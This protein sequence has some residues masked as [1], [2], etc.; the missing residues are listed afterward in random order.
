MCVVSTSPPCHG[1]PTSRDKPTPAPGIDTLTANDASSRARKLRHVCS[2]CASLITKRCKVHLGLADPSL[3][4]SQND[5]T[6]NL[7][8]LSNLVC[9]PGFDK[10][11]RRYRW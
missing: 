5:N 7:E 9:S 6:L 4:C 11:D 8:R 1:H 10:S 3:V 2:V